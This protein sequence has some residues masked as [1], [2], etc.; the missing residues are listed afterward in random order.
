MSSRMCL[1]RGT[2]Q[3][4][5]RHGFSQTQ[6][7]ASRRGSFGPAGIFAENADLPRSVQLVIGPATERKTTAGACPR[8][9]EHGGAASSL[10]KM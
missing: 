9:R 1:Q 8:R 2:A 5:K 7:F 4:P 10:A 3:N 6:S